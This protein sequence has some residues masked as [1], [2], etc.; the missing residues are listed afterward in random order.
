[1]K[2]YDVPHGFKIGDGATEHIGSDSHA[3]TVIRVGPSG[4]TITMQRDKAALD[5]DWK[6]DTRLGGFVGHTVNNWSQTYTY[7]RDPQ[8]AVMTARLTKRGWASRGTPV[9]KGRREFYD[10]NF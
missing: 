5:P 3:Y 7:E 6:P 2:D 9:S 8:G 1:V 10:Y 4:K